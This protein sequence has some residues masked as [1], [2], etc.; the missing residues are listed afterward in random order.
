MSTSRVS[1]SSPLAL[2][3]K[4][5]K[6]KDSSAQPMK[7]LKQSDT[8]LSDEQIFDK[9][10]KCMRVTY[11]NEKEKKK[12]FKIFKTHLKPPINEKDLPYPNLPDLADRSEEELNKLPFKGCCY[13]YIF[14]SHIERFDAIDEYMTKCEELPE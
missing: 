8:S 7:K 12:S 14:E 10:C 13:A 1:N 9:W 6:D 11:K 5:E 2:N 4:D 3:R